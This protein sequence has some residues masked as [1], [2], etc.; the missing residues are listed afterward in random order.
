MTN[1]NGEFCF[2]VK[3]G[4]YTVTPFITSDEKEKGLRLQ[5]TEKTVQIDG[6]PLL[7]LNFIQAKLSVNGKVKCL[8]QDDQKCQSIKI[9]LFSRGH[10]GSSPL[11]T[12]QVNEKGQFRFEKILPGKYHLKISMPEFCWQQEKFDIDVQEEDSREYQFIQTG[13][14][15]P[16][17]STHTFD[18]SIKKG[19]SGQVDTKRIDRTKGGKLCLD[20]RGSY[21]LVPQSCYRF[22]QEK[23]TFETS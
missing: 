22:D 19:V 15:M 18:I 2:E 14:A 7:N 6:S 17:E 8:E 23:F 1:E 13:Y 5:P 4:Q 10:E 12:E 21:T 11:L 20:Q 3:S 9:Q 16:Y